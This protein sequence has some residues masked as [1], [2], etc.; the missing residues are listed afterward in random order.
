[1]VSSQEI[2]SR[3][4]LF[5]LAGQSFSVINALLVPSLIPVYLRLILVSPLNTLPAV[6][7][8]EVFPLDLVRPLRPLRPVRH[9][10]LPHNAW[11]SYS[12]STVPSKFVGAGLGGVTPNVTSVLNTINQGTICRARFEWYHRAVIGVSKLLSMA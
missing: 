8:L 7:K 10:P 1:M 6:F 4:L 9:P 5:H 11:A 2:L 3:A 12:T